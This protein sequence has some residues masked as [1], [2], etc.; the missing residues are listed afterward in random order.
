VEAGWVHLVIWYRKF[1]MATGSGRRINKANN[2]ILSYLSCGRY[3]VLG[4]TG[5]KKERK[6]EAEAERGMEMTGMG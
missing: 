2:N 6:K 5:Q 1:C 4:N 3:M